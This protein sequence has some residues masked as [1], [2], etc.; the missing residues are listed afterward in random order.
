MLAVVVQSLDENK[1]VDVLE[2]D[3]VGKTSLADYMVIANGN[4]Q[5]HVSALANYLI[6][7]IKQSGF[8][9][10]QT[11]GLPRADWVLLDAG[12]IIIHIFRPE[13]RSFYNLE[14]LWSVRLPA[15]EQVAI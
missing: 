11:E 4:S 7:D 6:K 8:K 12:D 13:V 3:L 1:A 2:I 9:S 10:P 5:R 15:A 14:K